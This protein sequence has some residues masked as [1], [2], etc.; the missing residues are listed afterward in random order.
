MQHLLVLSSAADQY[1]DLLRPFG[2]SNV[3]VSTCAT[4]AEAEEIIE[5]ID[6]ALANPYLL[7]PILDRATRL[8]W[9]QSTFAGVEVLCQ[10]SLRQDYLLTGVKQVYGPLIAEYVFAYILSFA[11][12]LPAMREMQLAKRWEVVPYRSTR[13]QR[14]GICGLGSIGRQVARIGRAFGM[15]V[16]G[17][18]RTPGEV[19]EA[20]RI[21]AGAAFTEF[22]SDLDYL[23]MVLPNTP[24]TDNLL[25]A[26]AL[27][28]MKPNAVVI[29]VGRGN[30]V[31][32][33]ALLAA[34]RTGRLAAAVLDV[35]KEEPLPADHLYWSEPNI[36]VTPHIAAESFPED[37]VGIFADNYR[38]W[39]AGEPLNGQV[40][41]KQGY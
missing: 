5:T 34:V 29:N 15:Y 31:D 35:F 2:L 18:K 6:I 1:P 12:Q 33:E 9:V 27:S 20:D 14:L 3:R 7:A 19:T 32:D 4:T 25:D 28:Q 38:R 21:Y 30:A 36:Y 24:A 22:L 16:T 13:G 11:R 10:P 37:L 40:D 8:K 41:F 39:K 26:A 17:Y 23:V